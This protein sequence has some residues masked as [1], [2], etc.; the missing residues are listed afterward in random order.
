MRRGLASLL[1][2]VLLPLL[3]G[4]QDPNPPATPQQKPAPGAQVAID[5]L[6]IRATMKDNVISPELKE[7]AE[8]LKPQ[9]RFTGYTLAGRAKGNTDV[10]KPLATPAL[11]GGYVVHVLPK[12][13][14]GKRTEMQVRVVQGRRV[15]INTTYTANCGAYQFIAGLSLPNGD[16]LI[17]G[18]SSK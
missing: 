15:K 6:A 9:F 18:V 8:K 2:L 10:G 16:D 11:I 7:L 12:M 5:V 1:V 4:G 13:R 17:L 14:A 3:S